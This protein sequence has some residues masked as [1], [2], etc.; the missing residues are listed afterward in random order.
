M[1]KNFGVSHLMVNALAFGETTPAGH[2]AW[3]LEPGRL[4]IPQPRLASPYS[5]DC[6]MALELVPG[7]LR[8]VAG[9]VRYAPPFASF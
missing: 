2:G 3:T 6:F 7:A 9:E 4:L 5:G 1:L 8:N